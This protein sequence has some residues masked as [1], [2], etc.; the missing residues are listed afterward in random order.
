MRSDLL[1]GP[2]LVLASRAGASSPSI[3]FAR[4]SFCTLSATSS[5]TLECLPSFSSESSDDEE[6]AGDDRP[7]ED[8]EDADEDELGNS[9]PALGLIGDSSIR[10]MKAGTLY[11]PTPRVGFVSASSS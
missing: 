6:E 10:A 4:D 3:E 11:F 9:S 1:G 5:F 7:E 2:G 8:V